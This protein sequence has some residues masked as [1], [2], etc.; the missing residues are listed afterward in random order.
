MVSTQPDWESR[1]KPKMAPSYSDSAVT[2]TEWRTP[3]TPVKLTTQVRGGMGD[4]LAHSPFVRLS[5]GRFWA[6]IQLNSVAAVNQQLDEK[7]NQHKGDC[8]SAMFL[9]KSQ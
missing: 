5:L 7:V 6:N 3:D 2:S 8:P 9:G 4:R 1:C